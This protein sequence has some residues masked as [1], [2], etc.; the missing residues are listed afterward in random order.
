MSP[1]KTEVKQ[2]R[3][4][5]CGNLIDYPSAV[6]AKTADLTT[7]KLLFNS[8]ISTPHVKF[9]S[10]DIKNLKLGTPLKC[11]E[12]MRLPIHLIPEEIIQ[13]YNL[14]PLV[15]REYVYIEIRKGM[16]GLPQAGILAQN[17]L[18]K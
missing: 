7:T 10:I 2:T 14:S 5:V 4:T 3:L 17:L 18:K 1:Q 13:E 6:S 8:V 11:Y 15:Y 9:M 16:Y 12:Y